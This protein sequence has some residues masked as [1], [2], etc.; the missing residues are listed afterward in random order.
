MRKLALN[1]INKHKRQL[2]ST[3]KI[4]AI[5]FLVFSAL[6]FFVGPPIVK[7]FV[8]KKIG[9]E[10]GRKVDFGTVNI[11][12]FTLSTTIRD[13][14]IYEAGQ[15]QEKTLAINELYVDVSLASVSR[16]APVI[17][18]IRVT[19]PIVRIIRTGENRFNF[20]DIIDKILAKP[21]SNDAPARF[22]LN[23]I[24]IHQGRIDYDD[25]VLRSRHTISDLDLSI[26][27]LSNLPHDV[28]I[29]TVPAFSA[30]VNGTPLVI[31]AKSKPFTT[32]RDTSVQINFDGLLLPT[33]MPFVPVQL[34]FKLVSALLDTHLNVDFQ[35]SGGTQKV[36]ISGD[37]SVRKLHLQEKSGVPLVQWDKL[38]VMLDRVEPFNSLVRLREI[39]LERP[40][41]QVKRLPDGSFSL[42]HA[43]ALS[44][45]DQKG[46]ASN[47]V[48][49]TPSNQPTTA[50]SKP[51]AFS[52]ARAEIMDG[53]INWQ[54]A[55]TDPEFGPAALV[56]KRLDAS[57]SKFSTE[58]NSPANLDVKLETDAGEILSHQGS[59]LLNGKS[60]QGN[61][62]IFALQPQRLRPYFAQVFAAGLEDTLLDA[63]L[64]YQLNWPETGV[65]LV[66]TNA[67]A[68]LRNLQVKL[69]TEKDSGITAKDITLDGFQFDLGKQSA[70]LDSV[71]INTAKIKIKRNAK[72]DIDLMAMLAGNRHAKKETTANLDTTAKP[73][74]WQASLKQLKIEQSD[75]HFS[76]AKVAPQNGGKSAVQQL[77]NIDLTLE[78]IALMTEATT[79]TPS[80][81]TLNLSH[82]KR[83]NLNANGTMTLHPF[84]VNLKIDSKKLAVTA[85]QPYFADQINATFTNGNLSTKGKLMV[86]LPEQRPVRASYVGSINLAD[87]HTSD[88]ISGDDFM[89]WKSLY[90]GNINAQINTQKNPLAVSLGNIALADF[91]ARVIVN[92]DG[93]LNLQDIATKNG[94]GQST[95]TSLTQATSTTDSSS[96]TAE[97]ELSTPTIAAS[98]N[99]AAPNGSSAVTPAQTADKAPVTQ[100]ASV[101]PLIRIGQITLQGG[102]IYFSDNFIKPNY[103][104]NLTGLTGSVSKVASDD[105][106]PA[107]LV[108]NG[109][110]DDDAALGITGKINPLGAQLFLDLA[111][112][113]QG[114][115][116]TRLTPYAAKYAGYPITKGKLSVDLNYHIENGQLNAK[117]NIFLDQLTFGEKVDSPDALKLPV[118]L[119][120]AL[121]KNSRGEIDINLPISGSLSDPKFRIGGIIFKVFINLITKAIISPFSLLASAFG[122]GDELGYVEFAPGI[123]NLTPE[124]QTKLATLAK[125]LNDKPALKLEIIGRVDPVTDRDGARRAYVTQKIKAQKL[126]SLKSD[127]ASVNLEEVTVTPEE[128]PK[129]L[130]QAYKAEKF[131]KPRNFIGILKSL[132]PKEMEN[133]MIVNA[134]IGENELK[135]LAERRALLVKR[136]LEEQGKVANGRMFLVAPKLTAEGIK[137][138]GKPS[139]VDFTLK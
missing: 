9:E 36:V 105:P 21:K 77:S 1:L 97:V 16:F 6:L 131:S 81:L 22:S 107:D 69:P 115:E 113:A 138:K 71:I 63:K 48:N 125:A 94:Q 117:N 112:K 58:G 135:A 66:L 32:S 88:K 124:A 43:F 73:G 37:A 46:K 78:N 57:L 91:Y 51:F 38:S 72:G 121:L 59:L 10:I 34:N 30:K 4:A 39:K 64:P 56:I 60:L 75:I 104:A 26:P 86:Q 47:S 99:V 120:V 7:S 133:L 108:M 23:N 27:F 87:I 70:V 68:H 129:F 137:D 29:F 95:P 28:E 41:I 65:N 98:A 24:H 5:V 49:T 114:I 103:S 2:L 42:V 15:Q 8:A 11:N 101:K 83:G 110:I 119:A 84:G 25:R 123:S 85:F 54:D 93:H 62:Q 82:N 132:P 116:L 90:I 53:R 61:L 67:S 130:E 19:Q 89:R 33:Y 127:G 126:R 100:N 20:S 122:G 3:G 45:T 139:R 44:S 50:K 12:P 128:Y 31:K 106:T 96:E 55:T 134:P 35:Q 14:A 118:L 52:V 111:A 136:H 76:D 40:D 80:P 109:K 17:N 74:A 79:S 18:E 102:N 13:I 92:A